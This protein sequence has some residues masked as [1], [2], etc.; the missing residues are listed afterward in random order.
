VKQGKAVTL[1][2]FDRGRQPSYALHPAVQLERLGAASVSKNLFQALCAHVRRLSVLRQAIHRSAPDLII[3]F[4]SS[5]NVLSLI[6]TRGLN[7]PVVISERVDPIS[8]DIGL[9]WRALRRLTCSWA[10]MCVFM[11]NTEMRR[12]NGIRKVRGCVIP[13]PVVM[14]APDHP[15]YDPIARENSSN[16]I[17]VAMGRLVPEKGFDLLLDAFARIADRNPHWSL[18]ILG[19]GELRDQLQSQASH[20]RLGGRVQMIGEVAD[21]FP[22][23]RSA[24]LFVLSSRTEGFPNALCE[25]MACGLPSISF[26]CPCGPRDIIRHGIDGILVP[27]NDVAALA[28]ALDRLMGNPQ[29]RQ[30]LSERARDVLARFSLERVLPRWEEVFRTLVQAKERQSA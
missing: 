7:K 13:N 14:T 10:N 8:F 1:L 12:F 2:T 17:L 27:P 24:D 5:T 28:A 16:R 11:T 23:L 3:S 22:I 9:I 18:L 19:E 30:R 21:P 29:E 20:L 25:A 4:L 15:D 26:D 6:A